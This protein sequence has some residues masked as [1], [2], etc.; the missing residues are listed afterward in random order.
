MKT[1][2]AYHPQRREV[3]PFD[4]PLPQEVLNI[5]TRSRKNLLPWRGQFSPQLVEVL[6]QSY[7][8]QGGTVL[9]PCMGSGTVLYEAAHLGSPVYGIDV[10]PA[11]YVLARLYECCTLPVAERYNLVRN[12]ED[13]LARAHPNA[14]VM[15]LFR[16]PTHQQMHSFD[17]VRTIPDVQIRILLDALVVMLNGDASDENALHQAWTSVRRIIL[18]LPYSK[19]PIKALFGDARRIDLP[20]ESVDFV[21][22]SPP[23]LN[24]FNYHHN[25][26]T[27]I[28]VLGWNPLVAGQS[29]IGANR[30][31]RQNR[32]LTVVQYC[33]DIAL[34]LAEICRVGRRAARIILVLGRESRVQKTPF[35]NGY[36]VEQIAVRALGMHIHLKQ[37]RFF[38]NRFGQRIYEDILHLTPPSDRKLPSQD[39]LIQQARSIAG[40]VLNEALERTPADRR[41]FLADAINRLSEILPSPVLD[42]TRIRE[43]PL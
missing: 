31:F 20:D 9:D 17:W 35:A 34:M 43:V 22:S 32:F 2:I 15:P 28:E 13:L 36:I 5:A 30:K 40:E 19:T 10:N 6:L 29:E 42:P 1:P 12:A 37:E 3:L 26:R 27:G 23:Y 33:I 14:F 21:L 24:V 25:A 39:L 41:I 8:P 18:N 16:H 7:A 11:A 38:S 4:A